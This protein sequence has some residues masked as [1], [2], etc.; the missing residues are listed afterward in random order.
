MGPLNPLP[1]SNPGKENI[2][3]LAALTGKCIYSGELEAKLNKNLSPADFNKCLAHG[4][5]IDLLQKL[6]LLNSHVAAKDLG[7]NLVEDTNLRS[8][9]T[10]GAAIPRFATEQL[11]LHT[12]SFLSDTD[13]IDEL[14]AQIAESQLN[15]KVQKVAET[16]RVIHA[17]MQ[18]ED[19]SYDDALKKYATKPPVAT[20]EE[21]KA[22]LEGITDKVSPNAATSREAQL[23]MIGGTIRRQTGERRSRHSLVPTFFLNPEVSPNA[24]RY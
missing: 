22:A 11:A 21:L 4:W 6:Y 23:A 16:S 19:L 9:Y 12:L 18:A 7:K 17:L 24:N 5:H 14:V 13:F 1:T 10:Y 15:Y 20:E 8:S 3:R 2:L